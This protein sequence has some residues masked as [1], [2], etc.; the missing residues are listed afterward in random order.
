[1]MIDAIYTEVLNQLVGRDNVFWVPEGVDAK[2]Y[3]FYPFNEKDIDILSFGRKYEL[4]HEKIVE[5]TAR[6]LLPMRGE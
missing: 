4:F 1:M 5:C 3:K 2:K 6:R